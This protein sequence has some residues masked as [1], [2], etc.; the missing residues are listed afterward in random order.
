MASRMSKKTDQHHTSNEDR[1]VAEVKADDPEHSLDRLETL[2]RHVLKV[3][4]E[5]MREEK[6]PE[7]GS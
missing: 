1:S 6:E 4:R 5:V 7:R 3:G 2:T